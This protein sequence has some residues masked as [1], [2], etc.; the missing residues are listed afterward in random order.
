MWHVSATPAFHGMKGQRSEVRD[1]PPGMAGDVNQINADVGSTKADKR[2]PRGKIGW[3]MWL[4]GLYRK[5]RS[6]S[7]SPVQKSPVAMIGDGVD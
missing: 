1:S 5:M 3:V 4:M 2:A 6:E 7:K